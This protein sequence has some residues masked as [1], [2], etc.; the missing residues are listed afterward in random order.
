MWQGVVIGASRGSCEE[1]AG[2]GHKETERQDGAL[3]W[4]HDRTLNTDAGASS[5][6]TK[7][8]R[9]FRRGG[10]REIREFLLKL[11]LKCADWRENVIVFKGLLR[12]S[13]REWIRIRSA[14]CGI[15][16][17]SLREGNLICY[18]M[19]QFMAAIG[20]FQKGRGHFLRQSRGRQ[21]CFACAAMCLARRHLTRSRRSSRG[22]G[23]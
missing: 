1:H 15:R 20:R 4:M 19:G 17:L 9:L 18:Q 14:E 2:Q 12:F 3:R 7:R 11:G 5:I 8:G 21:S 13:L 10:E 6:Q 22:C 23:R 16:S